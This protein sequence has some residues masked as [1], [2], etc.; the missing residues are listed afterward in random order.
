MTALR[1]RTGSESNPFASS[2]SADQQNNNN[3]NNPLSTELP[4]SNLTAANNQN[5]V[6]RNY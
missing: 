3:S 1:R 6:C 2:D 4:S 5:Q